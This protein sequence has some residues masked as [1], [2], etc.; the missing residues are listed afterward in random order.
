M[1]A[2]EKES[3]TQAKKTAKSVMAKT[4]AV[5]KSGWRMIGAMKRPPISS[6]R[7]GQIHFMNLLLGCLWEKIVA[8]RRM[9]AGLANSEGWMLKPLKRNHETAPFTC[10]PNMNSSKRDSHDAGMTTKGSRW[11]APSGILMPMKAKVSDIALNSVSC[12][13]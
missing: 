6:R 8:S 12:L 9:N 3:L 5:P 4:L 13:R 11:N 2:N 7:Y 10:L 1:V